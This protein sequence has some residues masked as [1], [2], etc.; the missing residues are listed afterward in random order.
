MRVEKFEKTHLHLGFQL[1]TPILVISTSAR[2]RANRVWTTITPCQETRFSS[3]GYSLSRSGLYVCLSPLILSPLNGNVKLSPYE[4]GDIHV[5]SEGIVA[6][7]RDQCM[8]SPDSSVRRI[9]PLP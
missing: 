3:P 4:T 2:P 6:S 8:H 5:E 9:P 1:N 7:E